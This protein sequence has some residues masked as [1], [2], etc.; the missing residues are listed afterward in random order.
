MSLTD[1]QVERYSRQIVLTAIGGRGQTALLRSAALV[2]GSG[3]TAQTV[4]RYL[5]M[6]GVG[7]LDIAG[8]RAATIALAEEVRALNPEVRCVVLPDGFARTGPVDVVVVADD[9]RRLDEVNR[10]TL[11]IG[12]PLLVGSSTL[13]VAKLSGYAGHIEGLP[14]AACETAGTRH[15]TA[16]VPAASS[17]TP[18]FAAWL[19]AALATETVKLLLGGGVS[20]LGLE[21]GCDLETMD[22]TL[23]RLAANPTCAVCHR[24]RGPAER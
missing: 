3:A 20:L 17:L 21:I 16:Q 11:R 5:S 4:V 22:V 12:V 10:T 7:R 1:A 15:R 23:R 24:M 19:G 9:D 13:A 2:V 8:E 14:C 6:A 18:A